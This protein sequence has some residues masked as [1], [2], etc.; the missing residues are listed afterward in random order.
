MRINKELTS[1]RF[2]PDPH[3]PL[4]VT[5]ICQNGDILKSTRHVVTKRRHAM[6]LETP[7][8]I[9]MS[10]AM[11]I[12]LE[13]HIYKKFSDQEGCVAWDLNGGSEWL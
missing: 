1:T 6:V 4:Q 7:R 11:S 9:R 5:N 2:P 8:C 13:E 10:Q 3:F 12:S